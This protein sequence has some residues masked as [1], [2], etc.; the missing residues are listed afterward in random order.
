MKSVKHQVMNLSTSVR[1]QVCAQVYT[2][3]QE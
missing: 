1:E 2:Q 3:V